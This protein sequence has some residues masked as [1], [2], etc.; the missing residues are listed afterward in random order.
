MEFSHI[1]RCDGKVWKSKLGKGQ[2]IEHNSLAV[3]E[4]DQA[5]EYGLVDRVMKRAI[6]KETSLPEVTAELEA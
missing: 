4:G 2:D 6:Q 1:A 5:D 3:L